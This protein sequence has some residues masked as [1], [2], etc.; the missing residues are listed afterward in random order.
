MQ[1]LEGVQGGYYGG[2]TMVVYFTSNQTEDVV[3]IMHLL[4]K[5]MYIC[6][7]NLQLTVEHT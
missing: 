2:H 3:P 1:C 5:G 7:Q 4:P 6:M